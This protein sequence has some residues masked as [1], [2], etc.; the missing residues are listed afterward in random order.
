MSSAGARYSMAVVS[1]GGEESL[2]NAFI[3]AAEV[4]ALDDSGRYLTL[5][6]SH[7]SGH[8]A[9]RSED[10]HSVSQAMRFAIGEGLPGE[11]WVQRRPLIWTDLTA[12]HFLRRELAE[13]AGLAC[14]LSIPVYAGEFLL[15]V[16]VLFFAAPNRISGAVEVWQNRDYYDSE[17]RMV[18]GYY[19]GLERFEYISRALTIM[20]GRGLPGRAWSESSPIIMTNLASS[21]GFIRSRNAAECGMTTGLAIPFFNTGRDVQVVTFLS[22][23]HTPAANCFEV[24][25]PDES[26]RYMLF[27]RGYC[28]A[29]TDLK[30]L[31]RGKAYDRGESSMGQVWLTGRPLVEKVDEPDGEACLYLPFIVD[32]LLKAVVKLV[33]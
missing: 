26:H 27:D 31:Y 9:K 5:K 19:G 16:V 21:D 10:F 24:W 12:P 17:L 7:Y 11:T 25:R 15:A 22:T 2:M 20:R 4:W 8:T 30:T 14:G 23:E 18:D 13:I 29:G 1:V 28:A 33:F 3:T 32:G 6:S